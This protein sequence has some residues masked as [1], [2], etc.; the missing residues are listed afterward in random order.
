M[1]PD[2]PMI[3]ILLMLGFCIAAPLGDALAK[4]LIVTFPLWA[5]LLVRLTIQ[6]LCLTPCCRVRVLLSLDARAWAVLTLRTGLFLA[7]IALMFQALALLPLADAVA[8]V[9]VMPFVLLV[10]GRTFL[11]E[12]VGPRRLTACVVGFG[13]TLLVMKPSFV[14]VGWAVLL[15]LAVAVAFAAY[16]LVTRVVART[17]SPIEMQAV[18]GLQGSAMLVLLVL[19]LWAADRL[20]P[21]DPAA[22][23]GHVWLLLALGF[24]GTLTHILMSWSL[25]FAPASTVA[26]VQYLEIPG[27]TLLGLLMFDAFPDPLAQLGIAVIVLAGLYILHREH[28]AARLAQA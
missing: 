8:I 9:Y 27:A 28:V 25:R 13:G 3:G 21:V 5:L 24:V 22:L 6:T 19:V 23:R 20:P 16:M 4:L 14:D 18:S 15:P 7:G 17:L 1:R 10:A 26:P 12:E 11:G 2:R